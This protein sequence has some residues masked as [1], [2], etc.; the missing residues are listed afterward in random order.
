MRQQ[1]R[2]AEWVAVAFF[3]YVATLAFFSPL[4]GAQRAALWAIPIALLSATRVE[5]AVSQPWS[6]VV[7]EWSCLG[8][9]LIAYWSIEWFAGSPAAPVQDVWLGWDRWLLNTAGLRGVIEAAGPAAPAALET[10]YLLLYAAPAA[11]L[12]V[13]YALGNSARRNR[14]LLVLMLGTLTAYAL[15]PLIPVI[16]PRVAFPHEDLPNYSGLAR[17][18][19]VWVL[20]NWDISTSVFPSGHVAVA[21]SSAFALLSALRERRYVWTAAF[22][23]AFG[24]WAATIYGRYH[25][26]VDGLA[27]VAIAA[28]AWRV[29]ERWSGRV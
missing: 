11:S 1:V 16:S 25:Y 13:L 15:L 5:T 3:I 12:G 2:L 24:V 18:I 10:F 21:F 22:V 23:F 4:S 7:R 26:A 29:C 8:L 6:R 19:N 27:S 17:R 14:F 28:I 9:I 20:D